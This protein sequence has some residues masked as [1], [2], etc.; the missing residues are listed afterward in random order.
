MACSLNKK[1]VG[2]V[3]KILYGEIIDRIND[4]RLPKFDL[5][6]TIKE[7]YNAVK[8]A[9]ED[10]VKALYYAQASPEIFN[11]VTLD[12]E[13]SDYLLDNDFDFTELKKQIRKFEDLI[14]VGKALATKKKSKEEIEAE[15]KNANK[16]GKDT[17]VNPDAPIDDLLLWSYNQFNGARVSSAW[18]TSYQ[19]AIAVNPETATEEEKNII[20]PEKKLF[21][22]VVK[23]IA[24]IL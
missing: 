19:V 21:S 16:T 7:I 13:V 1:Q 23:S 15:I 18:T 2:D 9:S 6:Q 10:E 20:D 11:L 24:L 5:D 4:N 17:S 22:D 3:Y 14:E 12:K 8:E